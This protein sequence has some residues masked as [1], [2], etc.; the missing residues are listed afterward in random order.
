MTWYLE[1]FKFY[2][3]YLLGQVTHYDTLQLIYN[4]LQ[5]NLQFTTPWLIQDPMV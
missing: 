1:T 5:N 2:D 3:L 4:I